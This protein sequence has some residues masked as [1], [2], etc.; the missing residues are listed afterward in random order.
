MTGRQLDESSN[1]LVDEHLEFD[2]WLRNEV[3]DPRSHIYVIELSQPEDHR[4]VV[5]LYPD[6][7]R[8]QIGN[9]LENGHF[10]ILGKVYRK[11]S[12]SESL[13]LLEK[14]H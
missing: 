5:S 4:V 6:F 3:E 7:L 14:V 11:V 1:T 2:K 9:E 10:T 8:D 12:G 13:D